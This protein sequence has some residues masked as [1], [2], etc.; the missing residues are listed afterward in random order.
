MLNFLFLAL[1]L[2]LVVKSSGYA[3]RYASNVA[4]ALRLPAYVIGFIV[5]AIISILPETFIAI[6]SAVREIPSF[7]LGMLFGSNVADLSLVLAIVAFTTVSGIRVGSRIL[8]ENRLYPLFIAFPIFA[9][10]DG[11]YSR[12][13]GIFLIAVGL[14]FFY[15][16]F[17][18]NRIALAPAEPHKHYPLRNFFYLLAS[19]AFLLF[20]AHM[21]VQYGMALA[22]S[23]HMSPVLIGMIVVGLGTTLPELIFSLSAIRKK[24]DSLAL[25]DVLG[26]VISDATIAVGVLAVIAP[27]SFPR[28]IIYVTAGFMVAAS[29]VLFTL[30]RS[31][32]ILTKK[33]AILLCMFYIIFVL[34]EYILNG[35]GV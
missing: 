24:E 14:L 12:D 23:V 2:F 4:H 1:S 8:E 15:L 17:K 20:G 6:D 9:G 19:M 33:E 27:F 31:G 29:L 30:M 22:Q 26:T 18:R 3:I 16:T 21:T 5:V 28:H 35:Q 7:G 10:F 34:T 32:K 25:G 13:E 11:Y